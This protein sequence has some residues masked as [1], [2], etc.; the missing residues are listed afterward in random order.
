MSKR[1]K[2]VQW[3]KFEYTMFIPAR[4]WNTEDA[5]RFADFYADCLGVPR[6]QIVFD[7]ATKGRGSRYL[8]LFHDSKPQISLSLELDSDERWR[9]LIHEL[10]HYWTARHNQIFLEAMQ[11][12]HKMFRQWHRIESEATWPI[13]SM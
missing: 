3:R 11:L 2:P 1:R 4:K 10:S 9:T 12:T 7:L 8:G 6:K 13:W 5:Q